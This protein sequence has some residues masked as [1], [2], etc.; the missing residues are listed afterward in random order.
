MLFD[1]K[2]LICLVT[3]LKVIL[4]NFCF[5]A[6]YYLKINYSKKRTDAIEKIYSQGK[7]MQY[8][9]NELFV[10]LLSVSTLFY[11]VGSKCSDVLFFVSHTFFIIISNGKTKN[12][13][14]SFKDD[15]E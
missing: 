9:N 8:T 10:Y 6:F 11:H 12:K 7:D 3:I 5:T 2:D 1:F 4:F 13:Q 14:K 15:G